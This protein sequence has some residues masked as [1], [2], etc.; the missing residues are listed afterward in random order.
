MYNF[1]CLYFLKTKLIAT[2]SLPVR[3][4]YDL[5]FV[6]LYFLYDISHY[7]VYICQGI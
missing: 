6:F 7:I 2:L 5:D 3:D 4:N 1:T